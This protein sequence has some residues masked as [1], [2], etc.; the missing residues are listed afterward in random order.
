MYAAPGMYETN[1]ADYKKNVDYK[2]IIQQH[3]DYFAVQMPPGRYEAAQDRSQNSTTSFWIRQYV[4]K[5]NTA[6]NHIQAGRVLRDSGKFKARK[7]ELLGALGR[8]EKAHKLDT[9]DGNEYASVHADRR[10]IVGL[11]MFVHNTTRGG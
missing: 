3:K 4:G 2:S 9:Q 7:I 11:P 10:L 1:T 8:Y 6:V 5:D